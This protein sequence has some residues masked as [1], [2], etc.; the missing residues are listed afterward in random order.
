MHTLSIHYKRAINPPKTTA[1]NALPTLMPAAELTFAAGVVV[2]L[3]ALDALVDVELE[4]EPLV[5]LALLVDE[6]PDVVAVVVTE[7]IELLD[8]VVAD[9]EVDELADDEVVAEEVTVFVES[10]E[11]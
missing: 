10:I 2:G 5:L 6:D 11:N 4:F 8:V 9:V 7:V 1:A 3:P